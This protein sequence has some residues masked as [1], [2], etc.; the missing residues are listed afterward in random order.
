MINILVVDDEPD[1]HTL[2][3]R[4]AERE[5]YIVTT[6]LDGAYAVELCKKN[7]YD[8]IIMDIMMPDMDGL[9]HV[10]K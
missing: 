7:D 5:N 10:R 1:I 9:K 8:I 3:K 6:A 2:V 4:Y